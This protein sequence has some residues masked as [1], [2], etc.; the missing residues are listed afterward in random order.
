MR[1]LILALSLIWAMPAMAQQQPDGWSYG[2]FSTIGSSFYVGQDRSLIVLPGLSYKSGPW[3]AG[4]NGV[5]YRHIDNG[6]DRLTFS[7][8]PRFF[9]LI[10]NDAPELAGIDRNITAD[11]ETDYRFKASDDL[12][13]GL[14][15]AFEVSG[16]HSGQ[17]FEI[18]VEQKI[19][20]AGIPLWLGGA[21][22]WQSPDL[23]GYLYGVGSSEAVSGRPSYDP[24]AVLI[25]SVSLSSGYP[26]SKSTF[27][28]ASLNYRILP[29]E[30]SSSPIVSA[31]DQ[32]RLIL[33]VTTSF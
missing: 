6:R 14:R 9:G 28:F 25:P 30:I 19:S 29:D 24:G 22:T 13:F 27:M 15:G 17:E 18:D 20:V 1:S 3:R 32:L 31:S 5:S 7:L 11:L 10:F 23:A 16:A 8:K 21:L 33:G 4:L 2:A 12:S 26:I